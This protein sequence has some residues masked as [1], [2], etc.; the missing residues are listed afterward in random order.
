MLR[1]LSKDDWRAI[2]RIPENR[3]PQ[4]LLLWGTRNLKTRYA[5]MLQRLTDPI[6]IGSPNGLVEDVFI[7]SLGQACVGYASVYGAPMAS[8]IV[9]LFGVLGARLVVQIGT[10]GGLADGL[11]AGD[12]LGVERCRGFTVN[13]ACGK[14]D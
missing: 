11:K 7:G 5:T 14:M 6:E 8:E 13:L 10:C 12:P 1:D 4:A 3:V 2:L 9:H